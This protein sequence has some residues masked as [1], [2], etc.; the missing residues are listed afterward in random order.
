[1][2]E[3]EDKL[4]HTLREKIEKYEEDLDAIRAD[5][6]QNQERIKQELYQVLFEKQATKIETK[7][8]KTHNKRIQKIFYHIKKYIRKVKINICKRYISH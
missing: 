2:N 1:M 5:Y 4:N 7:K 8:E 6:E 3:F